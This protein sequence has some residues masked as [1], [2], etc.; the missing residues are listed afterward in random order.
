MTLLL[1]ATGP[2]P[3]SPEGNHLMT[4]WTNDERNEVGTTEEVEIAWLQPDGGLSRPRTIW[5]VSHGD[6]L[7]VRS[8]N[9]VTSAWY[10]GVQQR[11][12]GHVRASG[13]ARDVTFIEAH[14]DDDAIDAA[15]RAKYRSYAE[16]I[17]DHITSPEARST[18]LRLIP[19]RRER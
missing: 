10:R 14:D 3:T 17:L 4:T 15:Y 6:D 13:I 16:S 12:E 11:H 9:G 8:V 1:N 19:R 5:I 18:T 2:H 7:Y